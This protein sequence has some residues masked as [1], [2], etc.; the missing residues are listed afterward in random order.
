MQHITINGRPL[1]EHME[2][3]AGQADAGAAQSAGVPR[4]WC[5]HVDSNQAAKQAQQWADAHPHHTVAVVFRECPRA[6]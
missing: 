6:Y 2:C 1:C 4:F 3:Q 5:G